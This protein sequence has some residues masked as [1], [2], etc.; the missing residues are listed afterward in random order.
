MRFMKQDRETCAQ[1]K[2][3]DVLRVVEVL[4]M[5]GRDGAEIKKDLLKQC[6]VCTRSHSKLVY[7]ASREGKM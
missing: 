4:L 3:D 1:P 5:G 6:K 7:N 2:S